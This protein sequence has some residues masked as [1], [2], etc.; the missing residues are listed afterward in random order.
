MK[1]QHLSGERFI[2]C[3]SLLLPFDASSGEVVLQERN[4]YSLQP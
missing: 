3:G 1:K 4:G 2:P